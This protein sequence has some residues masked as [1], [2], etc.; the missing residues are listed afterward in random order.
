ML[1]LPV[2]PSPPPVA[3]ASNVHLA[4]SWVLSAAGHEAVVRFTAIGVV[5]RGVTS[6]VIDTDA[7]SPLMSV[8]STVAVYARGFDVSDPLYV[9]VTVAV[10]PARFP[11]ACEVPSPKSSVAARSAALP[12]G[13]VTV[14]TT[15]AVLFEVLACTAEQLPVPDAGVHVIDTIGPARAAIVRLELVFV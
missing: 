1:A 13:L 14:N 3:A 7:D 2:P 5:T 4:V 15:V 11:S 6:T 9:W 12:V 10:P 8:A